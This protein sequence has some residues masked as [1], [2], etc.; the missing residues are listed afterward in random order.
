MRKMMSMTLAGTVA[1]AVALG[2]C[3][4]ANEAAGAAA[5]PQ[6]VTQ[7][8]KADEAKW[9]KQFA[10]KDQEGLVDHYADDAYFVAPGVAGTEG[11]TPIR[12][13]FANASTDPAFEVHFKSDKIDVAKS[14]DLAYARGKFSEKYTDKATG[15][16]MSDS[17]SYLT[18]YKKQ[19]D[20]SW[21]AVEDFAV[22]DPDSAKAVEPG[23]PVT[24]AKM[25]SG[26]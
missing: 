16:V 5:N 18:V 20:G 10:A 21:K 15:K 9:N 17:G 8:I 3:S 6:D 24:R 23:K 12:Q 2:G 11:S 4:K 14:G 25:V 22:A 7:A 19:G 13:I 26:M 1:L